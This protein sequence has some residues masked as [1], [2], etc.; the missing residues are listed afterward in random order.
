MDVDWTVLPLAT[1]TELFFIKM[2]R[3][4]ESTFDEVIH[5]CFKFEGVLLQPHARFC[6]PIDQVKVSPI[7]AYVFTLNESAII[8]PSVVNVCTFFV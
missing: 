1:N 8:V 6:I 7:N 4:V 5:A 2:Y 3:M